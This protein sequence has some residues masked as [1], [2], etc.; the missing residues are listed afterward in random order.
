MKSLSARVF[1]L[2]SALFTIF[3]VGARLPA[4][5]SNQL[6]VT[7][8]ETC[9][10]AQ[11][12]APTMTPISLPESKVWVIKNNSQQ[13]ELQSYLWLANH[14]QQ[15]HRQ[16][17]L[18]LAQESNQQVAAKNPKPSELKAFNEVIKNSSAVKGLFTLYRQKDTGK[19]YLEIQPQQ[20]NKNFLSTMTMEAGIG[21]RGIYSGMPLQDFLFYF[22]RVNNN[23][24]FVVRNVNFR[25]T[26]G[27]PQTRSL[28]R[29]FSDSVLYSIPIKSIHPQRKSILIDLG[30]LLLKDLP[31]LA[32]SLSTQ[33]G[34]TYQLDENKSYFGSTKAF[35]LN[36][37]I[38]S[39]YGFSYGGAKGSTTP[40]LMTLPDSRALTLRIRYS[41]SEL[42]ANSTYKPRLA[43]D[44]IGY[45]ITAYQDFAIEDRK[46]PFVRYINRWQLEK[47]NPNAKLSPPK[48]PIVFWI[49]NA[50]PLEYRDAV[51]EGVLMWNKAFEKAG[52][53]NAIE[54][55]QMPDD[56]KW[57]PADVR[58]NVIRWI[59][60]VDGF[61]ALGPSRVNPL[62]GE[63]LDADILVDASFVR[64]LKQ[65]YRRMVQDSRSQ[66]TSVLSQ[67]IND[68]SVCNSGFGRGMV[69]QGGQGEA[70]TTP[71][72]PLQ[73]GRTAVRPYD[74][75]LSKLATEY[76]LCYGMEAANQFDFGSLALTLF[77]NTTPNSDKMQQ[78]IHQYL[79]LIIAHEV[80]HTLGLRHNFRGSTQL[81][82]NEL[83][84][85][86]ITRD[87]GLTTSVMDYLPPNLAPPEREQGDFFPDSI[88]S[89]DEWAIEYGYTPTTA[90]HP[91][92]ER[93]FLDQ[94]GDRSSRPD[95]AYATDEDRFDLD[96]DV[97]AWDYSSDVLGYSQGQLDIARAMWKKLNRRYPTSGESY[98]D[99]SELFDRIFLHY[100]RHTYYA[101]KYI[102]GQSF[103]RDHASADNGRLP[104]VPVPVAKQRQ[105]LAVLEKYVFA[106]DAFNFPPELLNKLA[107]SRWMH[108][109]EQA[110]MNRLDYPIHD[111][112]YALQS[113]VLRDL[114]SGDRLSRLRDIELK[115]QPKQ[116]LTL[117]ELFTTLQNDIWMEVL[118]PDKTPT[119][120]SS[121]RR[122][123]Q[124]EHLKIMTDMML[125][126]S[127][128]PEDAR[129]LAWYKLQQLQEKLNRAVARSGTLDEYTKAH[130]AETRDR[131]AKTLDAR[132]ESR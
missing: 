12:C 105:A 4:S 6:S 27:S 65:E 113:L 116:A 86:K 92:A 102:G 11:P 82:P 76:D 68:R 128:V 122:A 129:T 48:K 58:Y 44:R 2:H 132:V 98:S 15:D 104:F 30:D 8:D 46:E 107:P 41:L 60:T 28:T 73:Y 89:Y 31:G 7:S 127:N 42:S 24:H 130:L 43:D 96:P 79:R 88:G 124:R 66:P 1:L 45:F 74:S 54:V 101:T 47:Q 123:V 91:L 10:G 16:S 22:Q 80:G 25:V 63:I 51:K 87:R 18:L 64:V 81:P 40:N 83:N 106:P 117:P 100:L 20:F 13:P 33:L 17:T 72:S 111:S 53:I 110:V 78:Y 94:I 71:D 126:K 70:I 62:T 52:F 125:R 34:T 119:N 95:L 56:A 26:P 121:L 77:Q 23:I 57:D 29:S 97:N 49:E 37:E 114:L 131:I 93:R 118:N 59:N 55:R 108:W 3:F 14:E 61:F 9:R 109:G 19:I 112:I 36:M 69:G 67:M 50:V 99:L 32:A 115:S 90:P 85:T 75:P 35:P 5:A 38:E 103:Y 84:A 120:I 21:E 39:V